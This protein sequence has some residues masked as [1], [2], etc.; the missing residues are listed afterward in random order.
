MNPF[1]GCA[2]GA[3]FPGDDSPPVFGKCSHAF[4]MQCV[5]KWL[6]SQQQEAEPTC[7]L[8]RRA[9]EFSDYKSP[10]AERRRRSAAGGAAG[11]DDRAVAAADDAVAAEAEAGDGSA[12]I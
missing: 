7:P 4:H 11:E 12:D 1:D 2:P 3:K 5:M 6:E 9:W 8:C 10:K